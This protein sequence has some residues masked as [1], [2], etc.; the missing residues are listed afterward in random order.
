MEPTP[1]PPGQYRMLV[2]HSPMMLWRAG[3]DAK[4]DYFNETWLAF[5]GRTLDQELGDGWMAGVHP[6]DVG[7]C[8][9]LYLSSFARRESFEMEYRLRR[10]DGAYRYIVDRGVPFNGEDGAFGGYIGSCVDMHER[11]E[12]ERQKAAF[13]SMIAHELRTPLTSMRAYIESLRRRVSRGQPTQ[14]E[15]LERLATQ[16]SRFSELVGEMN[17]AARLEAGRPLPIDVAAIDIA[18]IAREVVGRFVERLRFDPARTPGAGDRRHAVVLEC[19]AA[20]AP[21]QGD[22]R[23]LDQ[24]LSSLIDNAVKY[25]PDGGAIRITLARRGDEH[26]VSISDEGIGVPS[27]ELPSLGRPFFR[28]SNASSRNYPGLGLRLAVAREIVGRHGGRLWFESKLGQGTT[29]H[30][31]LPASDRGPAGDRPPERAS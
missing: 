12:A 14:F 4:C 31:A 10:Y 17:D 21:V 26:A 7:R 6:D 30:L 19:A 1:L 15:S 16:L 22:R 8:V 5:T 18:V 9:E 29:A 3:L 28:T 25:S 20:P 2:E 27:A 24:V 11:R 23:R 13:L